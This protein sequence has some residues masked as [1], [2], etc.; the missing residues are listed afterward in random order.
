MK[1]I[2]V[3]DCDIT[4]NFSENTKIDEKNVLSQ[5]KHLE[6]EVRIDMEHTTVPKS[7]LQNDDFK[8]IKT[9]QGINKKDKLTPP[10]CWKKGN[11]LSSTLTAIESTK[12]RKI[13]M[14]AQKYPCFL[15]KPN[16]EV[17]L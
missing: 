6:N 12:R 16:N 2:Q 5:D 8:I 9:K 4:N 13:K 7:H 17:S 3:S 15:S 14:P 11:K 10:G 1:M